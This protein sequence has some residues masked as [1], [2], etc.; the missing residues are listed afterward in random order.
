MI[1][2]QEFN[3]VHACNAT[4]SNSDKDIW[5]TLIRYTD[6]RLLVTHRTGLI[7]DNSI[8][9]LN[10]VRIYSKLMGQMSGEHD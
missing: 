4:R 6:G 1:L 2:G 3:I 8:H 7:P 5:Q 9:Q 10:A